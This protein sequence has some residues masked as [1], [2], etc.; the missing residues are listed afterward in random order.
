MYWAS[1]D[2]APRDGTVIV[3]R[4]REGR[5]LWLGGQVARVEWDG[6]TWRLHDF[7][8]ADGT[9]DFDAAEWLCETS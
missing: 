2:G 7:E 5:L 3:A 4:Q 9:T 6:D 1:I 8:W